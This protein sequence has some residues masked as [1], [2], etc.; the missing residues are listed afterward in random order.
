MHC[1]HKG[2]RGGWLAYL[3]TCLV[4]GKRSSSTFNI[5]STRCHYTEAFAHTPQTSEASV[6]VYQ[7]VFENETII[8]NCDISN[9]LKPFIQHFTSTG[10]ACDV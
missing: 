10:L 7:T 8:V 2:H 1:L 4:G 9:A 6:D 5:H 3:A